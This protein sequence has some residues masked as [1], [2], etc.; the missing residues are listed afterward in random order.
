MTTV[1]LIAVAATILAAPNA[2]AAGVTWAVNE[3]QGGTTKGVWHLEMRGDKVSGRAD[4]T[5][6]NGQR[7]FYHLQGTRQGKDISLQ[8]G[9][10]SDGR[11]C[12]YR[13]SIDGDGRAIGMALC[14]AA[15]STWTG[16]RR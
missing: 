13:G 4:M 6:A 3:G 16:V 12:V 11:H 9:S 7:V 14:G 10:P 2:M 8:R 1:R 5:T 15:Q